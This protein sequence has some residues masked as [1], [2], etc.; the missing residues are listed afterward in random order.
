MSQFDDSLSLFS[1]P[2]PSSPL[3]LRDTSY[4]SPFSSLPASHSSYSPNNS[5]PDGLRIVYAKAGIQIIRYSDDPAFLIWWKE[6]TNGAF[7]S[8]Q[9]KPF[10]WT[11]NRSAEVWKFFRDVATYPL[12]KPKV[13]CTTCYELLAHPSIKSTG[14]S[15]LTNHR[16]RG[17]CTGTSGQTPANTNIRK[18]FCQI[19]T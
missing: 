16:K 9:P 2:V 15:A 1:D 19:W 18:A 6:T 13:Q 11:S 10:S 17:K 4:S 3:V 7:L 5:A 12:G 14:T 8:S